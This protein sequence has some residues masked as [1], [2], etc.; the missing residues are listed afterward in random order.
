MH[1]TT[2]YYWHDYK[3]LFTRLQNYYARNYKTSMITIQSIQKLLQNCSALVATSLFTRSHRYINSGGCP[4]PATRAHLNWG[5]LSCLVTPTSADWPCFLLSPPS[6][7]PL[8]VRFL[9][10]SGH[11]ECDLLLWR[12]WDP[13]EPYLLVVSGR[14]HN[15]NRPDLSLHVWQRAHSMKSWARSSG[16]WVRSVHRWVSF[17]HW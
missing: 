14:W 10:L 6:V 3:L 11:R 16:W 1:T 15:G 17:V 5:R 9:L 7:P 2:N 12:F 8:Y 4:F 13:Q